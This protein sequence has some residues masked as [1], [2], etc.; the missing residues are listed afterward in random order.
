M[1]EGKKMVFYFLSVNFA[2]YISFLLLADPLTK[3][4]LSKKGRGEKSS[5]MLS[6]LEEI[7]MCAQRRFFLVC[8]SCCE[9]SSL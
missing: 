9:E 5:H 7:K 4:P 2:I 6:L 1:I 8:V 3:K